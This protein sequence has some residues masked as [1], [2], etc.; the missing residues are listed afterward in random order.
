[1]NNG[2]VVPSLLEDF[3]VGSGIELIDKCI[4]LKPPR[5][6]LADDVPKFLVVNLCANLFELVVTFDLL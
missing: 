5:G 6:E 4:F 2:L 3:Q 1:M